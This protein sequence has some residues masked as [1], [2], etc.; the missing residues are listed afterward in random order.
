VMGRDQLKNY[1]DTAPGMLVC[2]VPKRLLRSG[3]GQPRI[4]M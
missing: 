2:A 1:I 4:P 3:A